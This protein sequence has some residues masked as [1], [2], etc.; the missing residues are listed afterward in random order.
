MTGKR[1]RGRGGRGG[2]EPPLR[3]HSREARV[4]DLSVRGMRQVDI[5]KE[6]G[7]SQPAVSK[8]LKRFEVRHFNELVR[9][10]SRSKAR[11]A[12][13]LEHIYQE[14]MG[15]WE[16]SKTDVMRRR[17]RQ[18]RA[19]AEGTSMAELVTENRHGDPRYLEQARK[20]LSD[21]AK[22]LGLDQMQ[23][24]TRP[25]PPEGLHHLSTKD[26]KERVRQLAAKVEALDDTDERSL[27]DSLSMDEGHIINVTPTRTGDTSE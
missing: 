19:G 13:R 25:E 22:L 7:L 14:A 24:P 9:M 27:P 12:A 17:Q 2:H 5:A 1:R 23:P 16:S 21:S 11:C 10:R 4:I 3:I 20:A 26:F 6:V 18:T 15:A 8:L